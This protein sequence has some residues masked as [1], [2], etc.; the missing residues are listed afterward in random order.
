VSLVF[1]YR[2]TYSN[3]TPIGSAKCSSAPSPTSWQKYGEAAGSANT[4][5]SERCVT[6]KK[7]YDCCCTCEP[8]KVPVIEYCREPVKINQA[9]VEQLRN[10]IAAALV[11]GLCVLAVTKGAALRALILGAAAAAAC[12]TTE[13]NIEGAC[14][15]KK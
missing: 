12:S 11:V 5:E 9:Q 2:Y 14:E 7:D 6:T 10:A 3:G 1:E 15:N 8:V 13:E 4:E